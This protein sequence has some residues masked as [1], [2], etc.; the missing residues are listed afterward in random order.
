MRGT[1]LSSPL[2]GDVRTIGV[3]HISLQRE[4]DS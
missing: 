4:M 2:F 3:Y 1:R